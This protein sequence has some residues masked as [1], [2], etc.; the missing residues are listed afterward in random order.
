MADAQAWA[1]SAHGADVALMNPGG[2][3]SDLTFAQSAGEGDGEA[4]DPGTETATS[5]T[6]SEADEL[7]LPTGLEP[8][9]AGELRN[10]MT[11]DTEPLRG[12]TASVGE[13]GGWGPIDDRNSTSG[14]RSCRIAITSRLT[15]A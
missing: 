15:S 6:D 3:R 13:L 4:T 10:L 7:V 8:I 12:W 11:D 2:V 1:T 9:R 14:V 5:G